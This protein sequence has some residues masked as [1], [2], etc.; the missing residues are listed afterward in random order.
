[1][2]KKACKCDPHEI[3]EECPEWIFTLADLIMCMMGLFVILW[4]LKPEGK[5][6][7]AAAVERQ[8]DR[9]TEVIAA[10]R[11]A[12]GYEPQPGSTDPIDLAVLRQRQVAAMNTGRAR[13]PADR[14]MSTMSPD[15]ATGTDPEVTTIRLGPVAT[16]GGRVVFEPGGQ[17]LSAESGRAL[18]QIAD[19]LRGHRNVVIVKG[20][21]A[22]DDLP[23]LPA[24]AARD[25]AL[26]SLSLDRARAAASALIDLGVDADT[27][28]VQ[29]AGPYEPVARR[30]YTPAAMS[31]N[32][33]VEVEATSTRAEQVRAE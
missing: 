21:A 25:A 11:D 33:R 30:A 24:G 5:P 4:V 7:D 17:G 19:K 15:G 1:M 31:S 23:D 29:G 8:E 28:R 3:C 27:L 26:M 13:G 14:G 10:I 22:A 2:C 16:V 20:H 12:F 6:A 9:Q 32:R 18:G